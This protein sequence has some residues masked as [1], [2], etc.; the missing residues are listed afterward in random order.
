MTRRD[1][2]KLL[3]ALDRFDAS[4]K[5]LAASTD[6]CGTYAVV[7]PILIPLMPSLFLIPGVGPRIVK[8]V[9][10]LMA[11]LDVICPKA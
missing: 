7:K 9:R 2:A 3:K 4:R 5:G 10:A 11:G 1:L 8:A 6:L